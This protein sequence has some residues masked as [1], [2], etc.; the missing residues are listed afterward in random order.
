MDRIVHYQLSKISAMSWENIEL[1]K[2]KHHLITVQLAEKQRE[3]VDF[4]FEKF[5]IME[6]TCLDQGTNE[7]PLVC[8]TAQK[9]T[10]LCK[11]ARLWWT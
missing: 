7:Q 9:K 1:A 6:T 3:L 2:A 10:S 4:S 11:Q 5:C 8:I